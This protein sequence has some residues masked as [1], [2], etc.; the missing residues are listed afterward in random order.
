M[1]RLICI[2]VV[3]VVSAGTTR[4]QDNRFIFPGWGLDFPVYGDPGPSAVADFNA[5]GIPDIAALFAPTGGYANLYVL[6]GQADGS[7]SEPVGSSLP[8]NLLGRASGIAAGDLVPDPDGLLDLAIVGARYPH[9]A[10]PTLA[11]LRNLGPEEGFCFE[12]NEVY[13]PPN[14]E[15]PIAVGDFDGNG[16]ADV[17]HGQN[18]V[19][20]W[21]Q[22][23]TGWFSGPVEI[24]VVEASYGLAAADVNDDSVDDLV[25]MDGYCLR[26]FCSQPGGTLNPCYEFRFP[27]YDARYTDVV[28][29][30]FNEDGFL[31]I[32]R[33]HGSSLQV[34]VHYGNAQGGWDPPRSFDAGTVPERLAAGD[35]D[36]DGRVDLIALNLSPS[37]P[38]DQRYGTVLYSRGNAGFSTPVPF[39]AGFSPKSLTL[40]D[41]DRDGR[42]EIVIGSEYPQLAVL[43]SRPRGLI[44]TSKDYPLAGSTP[45]AFAPGDFDRDGLPDLAVLNR[46]D[47]DITILRDTPGGILERAGS[48]LHVGPTPQDLVAGYFDDD[49]E[50]DLL[51]TNSGTGSITIWHKESGSFSRR[52][53]L[54]PTLLGSPSSVT[55]FYSNSQDARMDIAFIAGGKV[56][57]M[58]GVVGGSLDDDHP[59]VYT[60][61]SG[62]VDIV[63]ADLNFDGLIDLATANSARRIA[64]LYGQVDG[65]FGGCE[66]HDVTA[67]VPS[68]KSPAS[69]VAGDVN[70]DGRFDVIASWTNINTLNS[71]SVITILYGEKGGTL[72]GSTKLE[73]PIEIVGE[74][75]IED[76]DRDTLPDISVAGW[77]AQHVFY[78]VEGGGFEY[79]RYPRSM[80]A[81]Y[82]F[83][84]AVAD[85][86]IDGRPDIVYALYQGSHPN[87]VGVMLNQSNAKLRGE[88]ELVSVSAPA[89]GVAGAPITVEWTAANQLSQPLTGKWTDAVYLSSDQ[90]WDI[91][92]RRL[93]LADFLGT[94]APNGQPGDRYTPPQSLDVPLPGMADG[95]YYILVRADA[96]DSINEPSGEV[97]NVMA[98]PITISLPTLP[99]CEG[100]TSCPGVNGT[101][102]SNRRAFYYKLEARADED[103]LVTLDAASDAGVNELYIRYGA[104]PTRSVFD[105]K[106]PEGF[107]VDQAIRIPGT[108]PGTYYAL[109]FADRVPANES[110]N[111]ILKAQMLPFLLTSITP[112]RGGNTGRVTVTFAGS[113]FYPDVAA[114]LL[115]WGNHEITPQ[116]IYFYNAGAFAATF[117]LVGSPSTGCGFRLVNRS[118][119]I[120]REGGFTIEAGDEYDV[121]VWF[122]SGTRAVR[123]GGYGEWIIGYTNSSNVDIP[124]L[125]LDLSVPQSQGADIYIYPGHDLQDVSVLGWDEGFDPSEAVRLT[126]HGGSLHFPILITGFSAGSKVAPHTEL[127]RFRVTPTPD[128]SQIDVTAAIAP[129]SED[130]YSTVIFETAEA[131]RTHVLQLSDAP[132]D[133]VETATDPIR[134][135][136]LFQA[137]AIELGILPAGNDSRSCAGS[138]EQGGDSRSLSGAARATSSPRKN[139]VDFVCRGI[140]TKMVPGIGQW[141]WAEK[142]AE[143]LGEWLVDEWVRYNERKLKKATET[144]NRIRA[145][146]PNDKL[147]VY[148]WGEPAFLDED[149]PSRYVINFENL[150]SAT[151]SAL[152]IDVTDK[153]DTG[154]D[155]VTL[156]LDEIGFAGA[157]IKVP[158]GLSHFEGRVELDGWTWNE[159]DGWHRY[160]PDGV[161]PKVP[162][163]VDIEAGIDIDTG[164]VHWSISC[165]DKNTGNFPEDPYAGFLPPNQEAIFYPD[166]NSPDPDN[167]RMIHPGEGYL[168]YSVT[169]KAGL[170]TG[171]QIKNKATIVF[172]WNA[173]M[174]TPQTLNT[175]DAVAPTS[176]VAALPAKVQHS[177]FSVCWAGQDDTGG[178]GVEGYTLYVSDDGAPFTVWATKDAATTC[179]DFTDAAVGHTYRFY[180]LARDH[181][182]HVEPVRTDPQSGATI[183]DATTMVRFGDF[184]GNHGVDAADFKQMSDCLTAPGGPLPAGCEAKDFDLDGDVDL[185][186]IASFQIEFGGSQ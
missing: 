30:D 155:P 150:A 39:L 175:I 14:A 24:S 7:L 117:N 57:V 120:L 22:Q 16:L 46:V 131:L 167:P 147:T 182:G 82:R 45:W 137:A 115:P 107:L 8:N 165:A 88:L 79:D 135:W 141:V 12:I 125:F 180:S 102:Q 58:R 132:A 85:F 35:V 170:P 110:G 96:K 34:F 162:L 129:M 154:L 65:T 76:F 118:T 151:A 114:A 23:P 148:G 59:E 185:L 99:I 149:G 53:F 32:A 174:D 183:P 89:T 60:C 106:Y 52:E 122:Y 140:L 130:E 172:D 50:L 142:G 108:R 51:T 90:H 17:A 63:A 20:L 136:S 126:R 169:P 62:P 87:S 94:L 123:P 116:A 61:G 56:V 163:V 92:D 28:V 25:V 112:D 184:D 97:G 128:F 68:D 36:G 83:P 27:G 71:T 101:F 19:Y 100:D 33:G 78:G 124:Y 67:L 38:S 173:P 109:A 121:G 74:L 70:S 55:T 21:Y 105:W 64:V 44:A 160:E 177:K 159:T 47:D 69:I 66:E 80:G 176:A 104:I 91:N 98:V 181:V 166:P 152:K 113:G 9:P 48:D 171:T 6:F 41:F 119:E 157:V 54:Y 186:D 11:I 2:V 127:I 1:N 86:D 111:F 168:T 84:M 29:K 13:T 3:V 37:Y 144:A 15:G 179:A 42:S 93:G 161:T 40:G 72:G 5:D 138:Q 4:A 81:L 73:I 75:A 26:V 146:D 164:V 178:S 77:L 143:V 95:T 153:L 31:D 10:T 158:A 156:A 18:K 134:W 139:A 43:R 133:L 145:A 49:D 103:L